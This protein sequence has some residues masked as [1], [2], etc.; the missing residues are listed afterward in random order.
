MPEFLVPLPAVVNGRSLNL[1]VFFESPFGL[2]LSRYH[3]HSIAHRQTD[4]PALTSTH[5]VIQLNLCLFILMFCLHLSWVKTWKNKVFT[6]QRFNCMTECVHLP[7]NNRTVNVRASRSVCMLS[8][9]DFLS[10]IEGLMAFRQYCG[11]VYI[12]NVS[13]WAL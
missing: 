6:M 7:L 12:Y 3:R 1:Y 9:V 11:S 5:C 2:R 10:K 13:A 4:R 8:N